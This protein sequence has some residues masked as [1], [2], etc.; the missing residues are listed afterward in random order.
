MTAE[1]CGNDGGGVCRGG[2]VAWLSWG[3]GVPDISELVQDRALF[4]AAIS[5]HIPDNDNRPR[6]N[7]LRINS[8][9]VLFRCIRPYTVPALRGR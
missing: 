2:G 1:E 6:I 4:T 8:P 7:R 5:A 3:F 9:A